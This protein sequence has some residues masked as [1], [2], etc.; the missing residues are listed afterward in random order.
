MVQNTT[1]EKANIEPNLRIRCLRNRISSNRLRVFLL[2]NAGV[3][4]LRCNTYRQKAT[5]KVILGPLD[6]QMSD[7]GQT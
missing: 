6:M 7:L 3:C 5:P 1:L 2:Q 4:H